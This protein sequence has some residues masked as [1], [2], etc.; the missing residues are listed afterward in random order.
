MQTVVQATSS[1]AEHK[2]ITR[3]KEILE[4]NE[5]TRSYIKMIVQKMKQEFRLDELEDFDMV[6]K[7]V[8]RWIG[9]S[10]PIAPAR[11]TGS[12]KI[13]MLVGPTGVGKTTT[14]A[15]MGSK[16]AV[17]YRNNKEKYTY[18]PR[19]RMITADTMRVAAQE[20][21]SRWAEII[22]VKVD[23][24]ENSD[25]LKQLCDNYTSNSDYI[26]VDTSGYSPNDFENIARLRKILDVKN[27]EK[28]I[29]L[30][31]IAGVGASDFE[32]II[33]NYEAFN[34]SSIILTK[35]DETLAFGRVISV[36][37]EQ[38]KNVSWLTTGQEVLNTIEKATPEW[39][40]K[41]L[42]GFRVDEKYIDGI[43]ANS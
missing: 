26:F 27:L 11:K 31:V 18:P 5:F 19:I 30:T 4:D 16:I 1:E 41:K 10:I 2:N 24:A 40:L 37:A 34:F 43:F 12:S 20:Q 14:V 25:D 42:T 23:K 15:K 29:Y 7:K 32:N 28:T 39:F 33:R 9:E 36:L 13:V 38:H 8:L 35:C 21:L 6:Q 22:N 17:E 3:V